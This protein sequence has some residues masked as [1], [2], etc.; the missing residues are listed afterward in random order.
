MPE[1]YLIKI[2][3]ADPRFEP[4]F[5]LASIEKDRCLGCLDC[6]RRNCIYDVYE[7]RSFLSGQLVYSNDRSCKLCL[8]C[9]QECKNQVLD[10]VINPEFSDL[11]DGYWKPE[12]IASLWHQAE[13]GKIP[14]SGAGYG[15]PFSGEGF[16]DM[17]TDMSEIVRPT[18]D[19]IHGREYIST[20]IDIGRK[21]D[22]LEFIGNT[23]AGNLPP[24][25]SIPL[26]IL[27]DLPDRARSWTP[28]KEAIRR[29]ARACRVPTFCDGKITPGDHLVPRYRLG[30]K[31]EAGP[32]PR[33]LEIVLDSNDEKKVEA[34]LR[35]LEKLGKRLPD[36][37]LSVGLPLNPRTAKSVLRLTREGVGAV[38]LYA[39]RD[40]G[41]VGS[42]SR[43]WIKDMV[44]E[45]HLKLVGESLRHSVTILAGG[46][47]A[48]AEHV[49]KLIVCGADGVVIDEALLIALECRVCFRCLEGKDCPVRIPE[50]D[51][52]WGM[53]RIINLLGSWHSQLIEVL[54]AMGLREVRRL[55]GEVGRVMFFEDLEEECF[56]PIFGKRKPK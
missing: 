16:D 25:F 34:A 55:R 24:N 51:V 50:I 29:A 3:H 38:H 53:Q 56:A 5:K 47:I 43:R 19:G 54:G 49:A 2:E 42:G 27:L 14:V 44:R 17:W 45:I 18:R 1:K 9:V 22:H 52:A 8:R 4:V 6:A 11:G 21:P 20:S 39:G 36:T 28:V 7:K 13:T 15:G 30:D 26:P 10:K 12:I 37:V 46:G 31:V 40:G 32:P 48:M 33:M 35:A 23:P 41:A